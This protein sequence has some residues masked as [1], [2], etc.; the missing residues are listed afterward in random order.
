[1]NSVE[2][3]VIEKKQQPSAGVLP[4]VP[5]PTPCP[6]GRPRLRTM[7]SIRLSLVV[8][9]LGLLTVALGVASVLVYRT[10]QRSLAEKEEAARKLIE[11]RYKEREDQKRKQLDDRLLAQAQSLARRVRI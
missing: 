11:L 10:A 4:L 9:F 1:M 5:R 2:D 3:G 8:Y 6:R 7:R